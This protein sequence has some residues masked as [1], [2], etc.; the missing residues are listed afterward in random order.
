MRDVVLRLEFVIRAPNHVPKALVVMKG[1]RWAAIFR[2]QYFPAERRKLGQIAKP[3]ALLQRIAPLLAH[4]RSKRR[5]D[6]PH[7]F[8]F[9]FGP[10]AHRRRAHD[11]SRVALC[12]VSSTASREDARAETREEHDDADH[13]DTDEHGRVPIETRYTA[14]VGRRSAKHACVLAKMFRLVVYGIDAFA[15]GERGVCEDR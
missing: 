5:R 2:V 12:G 14:H 6:V 8:W 1:A 13:D 3:L 9:L 4:A 7:V 10:P 11:G 15:S